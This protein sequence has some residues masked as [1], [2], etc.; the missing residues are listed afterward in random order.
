MCPAIALVNKKR[1]KMEWPVL[2]HQGESGLYIREARMAKRKR[3]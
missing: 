3:G 2:T 1:L